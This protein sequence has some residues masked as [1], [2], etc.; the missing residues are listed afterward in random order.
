[1]YTILYL[2]T[3]FVTATITIS[4]AYCVA[5]V[6]FRVKEA[7]QNNGTINMRGSALTELIVAWVT[8]GISAS[9]LIILLQH[10]V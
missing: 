9:V 2:C 1:M 6:W 4:V 8:L 3:G 7:T 10:Y 5:L